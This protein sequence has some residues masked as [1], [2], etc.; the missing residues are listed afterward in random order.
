MW[1]PSTCLACA[2]VPSDRRRVLQ[3]CSEARRVQSPGPTVDHPLSLPKHPPFVRPMPHQ[4]FALQHSHPLTLSRRSLPPLHP[5]CL[6]SPPNLFKSFEK[7]RQ[8][9]PA[10]PRAG[11][12]SVPA[13]FALTVLANHHHHNMFRSA[14]AAA[15]QPN[16]LGGALLPPSGASSPS[17]SVPYSPPI[18]FHLP[19]LMPSPASA[20]RV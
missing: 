12:H 20:N 17:L 3:Q 2:C 9:K 19:A 10:R 5:H 13:S 15:T 4:L 18:P 8:K 14:S 7:P 16:R 1:A 6:S 11:P